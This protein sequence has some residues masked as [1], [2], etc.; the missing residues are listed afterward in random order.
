M[1]N[2]SCHT[3]LTQWVA[4]LH[5]WNVISQISKISS[6]Y[7]LLSRYLPRPLKIKKPLV[8][9]FFFSTN[10]TLF[11]TLLTAVMKCLSEV[12][13]GEESFFW[14][15]GIQSLCRQ[16]SDWLSRTPSTVKKQC[17]GNGCLSQLSVFFVCCSGRQSLEWGHPCRISFYTY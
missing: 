5:K 11:I 13:S 6:Q 16:L 10:M 8:L 15:K 17:E 2:L 3:C 12:A 1:S 9:F 7:L 14:L 4:G